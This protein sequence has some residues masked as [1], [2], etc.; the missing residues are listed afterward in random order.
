M[1]SRSLTVAIVGAASAA[2]RELGPTLEERSFPFGELRLLGEGEAVGETL[3]VR[4]EEFEVAA[5]DAAALRG[6]DIVFVMPG[7]KLEERVLAAA[8]ES[9]A[10][11][12]D[13]NG[14]ADAR[15][16]FPGINDE[17]LE[18]VESAKGAVFALPTPAAAQL[19][20][21][22][23]PLEAKAGV[24]RADVVCLEAVSVA[25]I[26]GMEELSMQTVSLLNGREPE[27][28]VFP[29]RIAFNAIP[30]VDDFLP[31]GDT[32]RE[33]RIASDLGRLLGR[34]PPALSV[35]CV[36]VPVFYGATQA[37]TLAAEKP[38]DAVAARE[39]LAAAEELKV[40]DDTAMGVYPMP[41]LAVGEEEVLVGRVRDTAAGLSL[42][43]VADGLR[44][45]TVVPM[46]RLAE[47]LRERG[48]V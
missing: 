48:L 35:T 14:G 12:I 37:I 46:V 13:A 6:C 7:E 42:V 23:L 40:L 41:M 43:S 38:I 22:L 33:K 26:P 16:I 36:L 47:L 3:E 18:E 15:L 30:Q 32:V 21:I 31:G 5:L 1:A 34:Q 45:G 8:R 9:G 2:G 24:V 25:G 27:R 39:A 19:A 17:E 44:W 11:I 20:A 4:G 28:G 29:H 10:A